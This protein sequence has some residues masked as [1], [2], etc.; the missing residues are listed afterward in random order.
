[1]R[2]RRPAADALAA[3][4]D[5]VRAEF[6]VP[7]EFPPAVLAAADDAATRAPGPDH[8]DRTGIDFRTLDPA[9]A[10]DL[11]QAF[12][13]E[14]AGSDVVLRYAIADVVGTRSTRRRIVSGG[15][16]GG[17]ELA[18]HVE[19]GPHPVETG[20]QRVGCRATDS[21]QRRAPMNIPLRA[22]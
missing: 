8:V 17:R 9:G 18:R 19:L 13:V 11:D 16:H 15:Q 10:T 4:L 14:A 12:A 6:H 1:M 5:R 3:G 7:S 2:V 22:S 21:H 20:G